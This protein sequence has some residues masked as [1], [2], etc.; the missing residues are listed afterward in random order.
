MFDSE[1]NTWYNIPEF[2][3]LA[4]NITVPGFSPLFPDA[5]CTEDGDIC[6]VVTGEAEINA[7]ST[8]SALVHSSVFDLTTT[9]W[10][11]A[12][13]AGINPKVSTI[14]SVTFARYAVQVALQ[15]EIDAREKPADFPTGYIPQGSFTPEQYPGELYGTEVFEL[16]TALRSLAVKFAKAAVLDD[17]KAAQEA[18]ALYGNDSA[19]VAA[20]LSPSVVECD[21]ATSDNFWIGDL[22]GEAFENTTTL[23]TNGTGV[24]CTTQQEDNATLESLLRGNL[25]GLIDF[26][27]IILM[28]TAS[29]FDRPYSGQTAI[30]ALFEADPG[31]NSS[32][33]NIRLAGV[34]VIEGIIKEWNPTFE[35]GIKAGNYIGDIFGSL[36]GN[37][38]LVLV[39]CSVVSQPRQ[40]CL[41]GKAG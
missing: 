33:L 14:G 8:V 3:L 35:T 32:I 40:T 5:H 25:A 31:F 29:D 24:Y 34:K 28:R 4:K 41:G 7:A 13:I 22:L 12:G 36:G 17:N 18:R 21:T 38:I 26:S 9:Y 19:F 15:Y 6:Q 39:I 23:F 30:A 10:L 20:T 2:N 16:N 1:A 37:P 27:R 11:I